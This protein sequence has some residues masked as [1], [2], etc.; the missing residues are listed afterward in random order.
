MPLSKKLVKLVN[1]AIEKNNRSIFMELYNKYKEDT[2]ITTSYDL[3]KL[4]KSKK[5]EEWKI[6]ITNA[7]L[8]SYKERRTD[9][10]IKNKKTDITITLDNI[11]QI[12]KDKN[13]DYKSLFIYQLLNTGRRQNEI[14]KSEMK[15]ENGKLYMKLSKTKTPKFEHINILDG[16]LNKTYN[17]IQTLRKLDDN[18]YDMNSISSLLKRGLHIDKLNVHSLRG[19]YSYILS[20]RFN[21]SL[22]YVIDK[23]L[24]HSSNSSKFY[25]HLNY[26]FKTDPFKGE[27]NITELNKKTNKELKNMLNKKGINSANIK[28]F[29]KLKKSELLKLF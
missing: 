27:N 24:H 19:I 23:Y 28:G 15:K 17:D 26:D 11:K 8:E 25:N 29:N 4:L 18:K 20:L 21:Q 16:D 12:I 5:K 10:A 1:E 22:G 14:L 3:N 13:D 2:K 6:N 7:E 9:K